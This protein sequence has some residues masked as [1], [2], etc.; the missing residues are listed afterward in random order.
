MIHIIELTR[1]NVFKDSDENFIA[2]RISG[3]CERFMMNLMILIASTSHG[4]SKR[5]AFG[6]TRNSQP[7]YFFLSMDFPC[8]PHAYSRLAVSSLCKC[9]HAKVERIKKKMKKRRKTLKKIHNRQ[10]STRHTKED[11]L[12]ARA[13]DATGFRWR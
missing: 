11:A 8:H 5:A 6:F 1:E 3:C 9:V 13:A 12:T 10:N 4:K 7:P 2:I